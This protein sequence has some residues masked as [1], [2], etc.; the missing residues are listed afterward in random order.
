MAEIL[1]YIV[2]QMET[3]D[4]LG[5]Q[6]IAKYGSEDKYI[7]VNNGEKTLEEKL[8]EIVAAGYTHPT[9][10]S[11]SDVDNPTT[12]LSYEGTFKVLKSVIRNSEGHITKIETDTFKLPAAYVH[13]ASHTIS[14]ITGL[15][16]TL[17]DL[18]DGLPEW[19]DEDYTLK[20]KT[21]KG[22]DVTINFPLEALTEDIDYDST[23]KEIVLIKKDGSEIRVSVA[24]L[25]DVY[26]GS[27]GTHIDIV[28]DTADSNKIKATLKA[29]SITATELATSVTNILNKV[30]DPLQNVKVNGANGTVTSGVADLGNLVA[31]IE[32][33]E[34]SIVVG[35]LTPD[36]T[37]KLILDL[38]EGYAH[39]AGSASNEAF[40]FYKFSTD[41]ESHIKTATAVTKSDITALGI[42]AQDTTYTADGTIIKLTS[43]QFSH[44]TAAGFKHIP[45]GGDV[46]QS[47]VYEAA[48]EASWLDLIIASETPPAEL[49]PGQFWFKLESMPA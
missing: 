44:A 31:S 21:V 1:E 34:G 6:I 28:V 16:G 45:G 47:L 49:K 25:I 29:G 12:S 48:G 36:S 13:P 9:F 26:L 32:L 7:L 35:T 46:G 38:D 41:A 27:T 4:S 39:P 22:D 24:E 33:K 43:G 11:A 30:G 40:G 18:L 19:D 23:T 3:V 5:N 10:S 15:Q 8:E 20:F 2:R 14:E 17:D 37:G 42:P